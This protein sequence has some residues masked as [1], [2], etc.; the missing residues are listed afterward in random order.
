MRTLVYVAEVWAGIASSIAAA[1]TAIPVARAGFGRRSARLHEAARRLIS[2]YDSSRRGQRLAGRLEMAMVDTTPTRWRGGQVSVA[3]GVA[4]AIAAAG[5]SPLAGLGCGGAVARIG[6]RAVLR[7][8]RTRRAQ[9]LEVAA[10]ALARSLAAELHS[11]NGVAGAVLALRDAH[12]AAEHRVLG[13][14]LVRAAAHI[15]TGRSPAEALAAAFE[16]EAVV[17][18]D[19]AAGARRALLRLTALVD[20]QDRFGGSTRPLVRLADAL[21]EDRR[22]REHARALTSEPRVAAIGVPLLALVATVPVAAGDGRV[23]AAALS[24]LEAALLGTCMA[25]AA[26][27]VGLVRRITACPA[28]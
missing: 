24:P 6:A 28:V 25:L 10:A 26:T 7:S 4:A 3:V 21:D 13:R 14:P 19:G 9:A 8:R 11:G 1:R 17:H 16:A 20:L 18:G 23:V 15:A 12:I 2:A 5:G 22:T 27:G